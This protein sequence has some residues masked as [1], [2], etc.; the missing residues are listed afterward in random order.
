MFDGLM[1]GLVYQLATFIGLVM[2]LLLAMLGYYGL[3]QILARWSEPAPAVQAL[4]FGLILVVI[5]LLS[6]IVGV[7]ARRRARKR[8]DWGDDLGGALLG[9]LMG[10][11]VVVVFT[12]GFAGLDVSLAQ[13]IRT[14][15]VGAWL[16]QLGQRLLPLAP[17][18]VS[19]PW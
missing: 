4:A 14:S 11:C 17:P 15:R 12:L 19:A 9:L 1:Q 18:W 6:H 8:D 7:W 10:L 5:W 16:L 2:G 3:A 13:E